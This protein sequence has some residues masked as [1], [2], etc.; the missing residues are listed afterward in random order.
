[1]PRYVFLNL[2]YISFLI[3]FSELKSVIKMSSITIFLFPRNLTGITV[4]PRAIIFS[5][6]K[7]E[8]QHVQQLDTKRKTLRYR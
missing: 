7:R 4:S 1:M 3:V 2:D 8:E 6:K 5:V